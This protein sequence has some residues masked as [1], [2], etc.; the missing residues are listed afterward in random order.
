VPSRKAAGFTD[1]LANVRH[2]SRRDAFLFAL[3]QDRGLGHSHADKRKKVTTILGDAE[4]RSWSDAVI[5]R[6]C[7]VSPPFVG[8]M[9]DKLGIADDGVRRGADG[10]VKNVKNIGAKPKPKADTGPKPKA[11]PPTPRRSRTSRAPSRTRE[12]IQTVWSRRRRRR[13]GTAP[14]SRSPS[15]PPSRR[16]S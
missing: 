16:R 11:A 13:T 12:V 14:R 9:R 1:I 8:T 7:D 2:G 6:M 4:L 5:A 3:T 10:K 15:S